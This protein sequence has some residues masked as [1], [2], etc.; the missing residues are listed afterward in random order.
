M[1]GD[2]PTRSEA[3]RRFDEQVAR[4]AAMTA[5]ELD[6]YIDGI[7]AEAALR[8]PEVLFQEAA[9]RKEWTRRRN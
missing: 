4:L 6:D 2:E 5:S 8:G 3:L 1:N 7:E 9:A